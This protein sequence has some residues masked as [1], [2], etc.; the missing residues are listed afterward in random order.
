[1]NDELVK[2][3]NNQTF[4]QGSASLKINY[5]NPKNLTVQHIPVKERGKK[6]EIN[7]LRKSSIIDVLASVDIQEIV[8]IG[9]KTRRSLWRCYLSRKF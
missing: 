7:R 3:I 9:G 8:K 4:T 5:H 1:M 2:N 6:M